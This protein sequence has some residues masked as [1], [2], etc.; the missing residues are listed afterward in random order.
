[1]RILGRADYQGPAPATQSLAADEGVSVLVRPQPEL[2][3]ALDSDIGE[4]D[5]CGC[6]GS[7][8]SAWSALNEAPVSEL[9]L[10]FDTVE[11]GLHD[12]QGAS[13]LCYFCCFCEHIFLPHMV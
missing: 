1:M 9:Q 3:S 10:L 13:G 11:V 6:A 12:L 5:C 8:P 2:E 4:I 7:C